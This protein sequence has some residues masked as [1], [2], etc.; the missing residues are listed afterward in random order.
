MVLLQYKI[1]TTFIDVLSVFYFCI[2]D[3]KGKSL[4]GV[5]GIPEYVRRGLVDG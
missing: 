4:R 2:D 1:P 3:N 5:C